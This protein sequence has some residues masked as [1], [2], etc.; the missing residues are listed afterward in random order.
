MI[1]SAPLLAE[2]VPDSKLVSYSF[3]R[4]SSQTFRV[5]ATTWSSFVAGFGFDADHA[6]VQ[7]GFAAVVVDVEGVVRAL[8]SPAGE[9][10]QPV[11]EALH[12]FGQFGRLRDQHQFRLP[13]PVAGPAG[14]VRGFRGSS[15]LRRASRPRRRGRTAASRGRS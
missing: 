7:R 15:G 6:Q 2:R 1:C 12:V 9:G 13:F 8:L 11:R 3:S 4:F 5:L 14:E 10:V